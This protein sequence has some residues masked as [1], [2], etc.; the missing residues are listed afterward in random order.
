MTSLTKPRAW[1]HDSHVTCCDT[2]DGTGLVHAS[3]RAT[4]DD[5]YPEQ[6][7][8]DC[9]GPAPAECAVC[10]YD[11]VHAGYDCLAC[12]VVGELSESDAEHFGVQ[13]FALALQQALNAR[14]KHAE[15]EKARLRNW[16]LAA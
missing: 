10:G 5:P 4:I 2:C 3:R 7:C 9:A 15:A 16:G 8:E 12:Y 13:T 6:P 11:V 1:D 14:E